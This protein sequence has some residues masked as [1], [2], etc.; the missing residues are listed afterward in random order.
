MA[1]KVTYTNTQ[2]KST[3][4]CNHVDIETDKITCYGNGYEWIIMRVPNDKVEVD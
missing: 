3:I 4:I 2:E 1:V